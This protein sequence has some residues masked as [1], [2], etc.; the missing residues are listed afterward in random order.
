MGNGGDLREDEARLAD[1]AAALADGIVAT[2]PGW[3]Q[4]KVDEVASASPAAPDDAALE[5][6]R[7]AAAEAGRAAAEEVG[8]A[9]RALLSTDVDRQRANPLALLRGAVVYPTAVLRELGVAPVRRDAVA[10]EQFPDDDYDLTPAGFADIDPA[11]HDAGIT[12]GAAKAHVVLARR[13]A[14]GRR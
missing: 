12:W 6:A 11:L 3:V 13:R 10:R 4:R 7:G 1:Y 14:E 5:V 2:L 8:A 9:V